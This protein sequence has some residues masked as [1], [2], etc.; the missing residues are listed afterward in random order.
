LAGSYFLVVLPLPLTALNADRRAD[1]YL[2]HGWSTA[3]GLPSNKIRAVTQSRDGY[4]WIATAHG[5]ARYDGH[6]FTVFTGVT[7]PELRGGGFFDVQE[8]PDGSLWFGG[9]NGLFRWRQGHFDHFTTEQG[10]AHNYVRALSLSRTG[11]IVVCTRGGY[12]F[13]H[14][15]QINTPR[16]EWTKVT[17]VA[18]SYLEQAD[19][20]A[21][22]A[23]DAGLW[24]EKDGVVTPLSGPTGLQGHTFT[25]LLELAD[26]STCIGYSG[27]IRRIYSNG[28]IEDYGIE[29][30]LTT[31]RVASL[32]ADRE[33]NLWIGT[34]G[35]GL[36]RLAHGHIERANYPEQFSGATIQNLAEDREGGFWVSTPTGLFQL[37][38]NISDSIGLADGL[39]KTS[40]Y[41][42]LEAVDGTWW[43]GLWTGGVYRYDQRRATPLPVPPT[44]NLDQVLSLAEE[45]AGTLWVGTNVGLFRHTETET[46]NL[47]HREKAAAGL[48]LLAEKPE[49]VLPAP[50][51]NRINSIAPDGE[52]GLWLAADGALYH[53]TEGNFRAYTTTDGLPGNN[54]KAVLRA[55][56]G[57][58]WVTVPPQGVACLRA[59]HWTTYFCGQT[60]SDITPRAVY[61]DSESSIWITTEGGG[62]NRFKDGKWRIFTAKDGLADDFISGLIEDDSKNLWIAHPRGLMRI[63]LKEFNE[64][65]AGR[66]RLL[67]SRLFTGSDGL[68][69]GEANQAGLPNAWRT[70]DGRLLFS[71]DR[72]V[73]V[74]EPKL[75]KLNQ[76]VPPMQIERVAINGT[77]ANLALPLVVPPGANGIQIDY[78]AICLLA[79]D[80][81]RFKIRLS[82]IDPDWVEVGTRTDTR[83][84]QLPPGDYNFQVIACNNDGVWNEE[85]AT[86]KF[87]V[88][89]FLYQKGWFIGLMVAG[90]VA[91]IYGLY[92]IRARR[93]RRR[94]AELEAVVNE[95]TVELRAAKNSAEDAARAKSEFL[96]NMSHE[97]RTPMNGVLGM[98]ELLLDT[99]LAPEQKEFAETIR[100][101]AESLL[102]IINDILDFSKIEAGKLLFE[103]IDFN[104]VDVVEGSLEVLAER[105]QQKGIE[106]AGTVSPAVPTRLR[107]DPGRL[108]QVLIN[109]TGNGIKFTERGEVVVRVE[110]VRQT[111]THVVLRFNIADTGIGMT[112]GVQQK[113]FQAFTQADSS[114]TRK[115]GGTGLGLAISKQLVGLME[116]EIGVESEQGKGT[117]FWFAAKFEKQTGP[118]PPAPVYSRELFDLR[119]L[120]VDDNATNRE[121]LHHQLV[122]W[123]IEKGSAASGFEALQKLRAAA[124]AGEPYHL[125]L[126]DMQMP[127]MDGLTLTR[128]IKA[129]PAIADTQLIILTSLGRRMTQAELRAAGID[130]YLIKP[131]KQSKLFDCLV[132][133]VGSHSNHEILRS[134]DA[135]SRPASD[136]ALPKARILLAEDN[137]VNQK[138][139]QAQLGKLGLSADVVSNGR[140]VLKALASTSY[141]LVLMDC[142]MPEVDGYEATMQIRR[143]EAEAATKGLSRAR[144]HIIAMTA[145]AMQGDREKCIEAGMDDYISK[146]VRESDLRAAL[147]RWQKYYL[148]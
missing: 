78:T 127:E 84:S 22:L 107:G 60:I 7:N 142:Q 114:T 133:V 97:I 134:A 115:Y 38:D 81:V 138:V 83:Y 14:N 59:G 130:A 35:G 93:A 67:Q 124:A 95:R 1:S 45:P 125:A 54:F 140:E 33:G 26:G 70:R 131:V 3:E 89:P 27:G 44:L 52:G 51:H 103:V 13:V 71:T 79:P 122:A 2:I 41:S 65:D 64:M 17:G 31:P 49:T 30:G 100:T 126:L 8:A 135:A 92:W 94:V 23:T 109:L 88:Q 106:L 6:R 105:A 56:D 132:D 36:F 37:T 10:L 80:K 116:G 42:V 137:A 39:E 68:P 102:T 119:V 113:L 62:L 86:L 144:C 53:G 98:T 28:K 117:T 123:K 43:I 108:R 136:A 85:G 57:A 34:Y 29:A 21:L 112:P 75:L 74:I 18:R 55:R 91:G 25:S 15:G 139:A 141:D 32:H 146:P 24:R 148:G 128:E 9:D 66:R 76:L 20:S 19:G 4:L 40:V 129:D 118:L 99:K 145:N 61:E 82:P 16:G 47:F 87:T 5:I 96:A 63:A 48:K 111:T 58:I 72:G 73:A 121:I 46:V 143:N 147:E 12:S 11:D 50:V 110:L 90:A 104:V 120:V 69:A 101:S 77:T